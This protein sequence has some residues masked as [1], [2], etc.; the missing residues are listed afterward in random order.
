MTTACD[1]DGPPISLL[2]DRDLTMEVLDFRAA[3]MKQWN[4]TAKDGVPLDAFISPVNPAV[5]PRH[6]DYSKVR[7]F[8]YTAVANVL[9]YPVCTLPVGLVDPDVDLADDVS[10]IKDVKGNTLPA[11]TCERDETIRR[12]HD[13]KVYADMPVTIQ[14][15]G[16]RFEDEKVIGI[17]KMISN[18]LSEKQACSDAA[19]DK[20]Y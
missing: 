3:I 17:V 10:L 14:V 19:L 13:P 5:A 4:D 6:G 1:R 18:L 9:D 12:K 15:I 7:Y 8:A 2:E 11:P 20:S 16:R